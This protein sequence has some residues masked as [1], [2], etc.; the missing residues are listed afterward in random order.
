[1]N[2]LLYGLTVIFP[3]NIPLARRLA[4]VD[5]VIQAR[6]FLSDILRQ[7]PVAASD[8]VQFPYQL[9]GILNSPSTG[10]RAKIFCLILHHFSGQH[11]PR[12]GFVYR[13]LNERIGF[14]IHQHGVVFGA[15]FLNQVTL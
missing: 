10:V 1:M 2:Y 5:M 3:G 4:L 7:F 12:E 11:D 14:I 6:S 8:T 15:V 13:H 9:N